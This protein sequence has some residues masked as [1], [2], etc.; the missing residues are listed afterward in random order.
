[1]A[2][3][4]DW[5]ADDSKKNPK[6]TKK[7]DDATS[8]HP[9][10]ITTINGKTVIL[11][12]DGKPCRT[13]NSFSTFAAAMGTGAGKGNSPSTSSSFSSAATAAATATAL[14][15][16]ATTVPDTLPSDCP[17]DVE[18][19]GR[20]TWTL[21]HSLAATYPPSASVAEQNQMG[22]FM[23]IFARVYPCWYCAKD[24]QGWMD[25][26]EN[27]LERYLGGRREFGDW[28][29]R[30]HNEVNKKLGKDEFDCSKWE[31]RWLSGW[32]DGRCG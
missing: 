32:K 15:A 10:R 19:L 1:M 30:A 5:Q 9:G 14:T 12:K 13:C 7:V 8:A 24:F 25:R 21:L 2:E 22:T 28:M 6:G 29:C 31:E 18:A 27:K 16:A 26:D 20:G 4:L 17:P 11:D 23:R 3:I